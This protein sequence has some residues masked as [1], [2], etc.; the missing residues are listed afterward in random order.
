MA[1]V[2]VP[3]LPESVLPTVAALLRTHFPGADCVLLAGSLVR[4]QATATSDL[5]LVVLHAR[6]DHAHRESLHCDGWPVEAF[7]HDLETLHHFFV[8]VDRP[9]GVAPLAS[10]VVE[11]LEVPGPTPLAAAAKALAR[12]VLAGG[13]PVL[14]DA[15]LRQRR[16]FVSDVADDLRAPRPHA[17]VLGAATSLYQQLADLYLR[18]RGRWSARA[19]TIPRALT[20]VDAAFAARFVAGFD[21]LVVRAELGPVQDLVDEVLAP[22]GGRL[23]QGFRMDA[24]PA[25]RKPL[26][27]HV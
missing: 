20:A 11:G 15:A 27:D 1:R 9:T 6:V 16:Y 7:V 19:K 8:E 4:G 13:P 26:P 17:E 23:F 18:S 24:P 14:D 5:D 12:R 10:M 3:A 21:A 22:L 25:W 2:S